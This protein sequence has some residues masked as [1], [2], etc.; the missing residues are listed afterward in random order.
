MHA[1]LDRLV[2]PCAAEPHPPSAAL[3]MLS[4]SHST[5]SLHSMPPLAIAYSLSLL[6]RLGAEPSTRAPCRPNCLAATWRAHSATWPPLRDISPRHP[7][8]DK[9]CAAQPPAPFLGCR[10]VPSVPTSSVVHVSV[11]TMMSSAHA[12]A[13]V[14]LPFILSAGSA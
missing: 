1:C 2:P 3:P 11:P 13:S 4:M 6:C 5:T 10:R 8:M 12:R 7:R 9:H 14:R